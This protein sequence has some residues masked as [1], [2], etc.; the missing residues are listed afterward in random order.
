[1][2]GW[3]YVLERREGG[4][5]LLRFATPNGWSDLY[6]FTLEA[7]RPIDYAVYNHFTTTHPASPFVGRAV[8]I[9]TAPEVRHTLRGRELSTVSPDGSTRR[10]ELTDD[11]V[12]GVLRDTFGVVLEPD[13][14]VH[15]RLGT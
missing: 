1:M 4:T 2:G 15:L 14:S 11:E 8:A 12:P 7:Q 6:A 5:W 9:R 13:E 3:Q 10:R